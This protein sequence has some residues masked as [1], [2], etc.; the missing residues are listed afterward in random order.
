MALIR[1][2]SKISEKDMAFSQMSS[3]GFG[4]GDMCDGFI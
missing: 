1:L 3:D 2:H 4:H